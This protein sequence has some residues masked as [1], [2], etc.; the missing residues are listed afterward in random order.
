M[1]APVD[2]IVMI[3]SGSVDNSALTG[4]SV[5]IAVDVGSPILAGARN[6]EFGMTYRATS[7]VANSTL[8]KVVDLVSQ[9]QENKGSGERTSRWFGE[10]YTWFV[11][12]A[13]ISML[14]VKLAFHVPFSLAA[15][16]SL[17][18]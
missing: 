14:L 13:S 15:Y 3:G 1:T 8:Q 17:T 4:E 12:L 2:G 11:L 7:T 18:C 6:L 16:S 5:P 10:R 9:A